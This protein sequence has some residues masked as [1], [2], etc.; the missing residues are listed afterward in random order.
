MN[1]KPTKKIPARVIPMMESDSQ[2]VR[3]VCSL[4]LPSGPMIRCTR[5]GCYSHKKCI[6]V[7][8]PFICEFCH[9]SS[10]RVLEE[11]FN[12]MV[13]P[14]GNTIQ[15]FAL[16]DALLNEFSVLE[17]C[18]IREHCISAGQISTLLDHLVIYYSALEADLEHVEQFCLSVVETP[19][20]QEQVKQEIEMKRNCYRKMCHLACELKKEWDSSKKS[21]TS[22][23]YFRDAVVQ[24]LT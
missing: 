22:L 19:E 4:R 12:C 10:Q 9:Q 23:G 2:I 21:Y 17:I 1:E 3:C 24:S 8:D 14:S 7:C 15:L 18:E 13:T 11:S 20:L 5:C 6:T 16:K